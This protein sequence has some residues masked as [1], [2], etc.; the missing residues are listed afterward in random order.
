MKNL[1]L[2]EIP[3]ESNSLYERSNIKMELRLK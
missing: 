1:A 3:L 2:E